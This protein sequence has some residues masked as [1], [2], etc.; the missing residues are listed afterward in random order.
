MKLNIVVPVRPLG[1]GK[2][3]LTGALSSAAR[4]DLVFAMYRHVV[5]TARRVGK[6]HVISRDAALLASAPNAIPELGTGLNAALR[7]AAHA[8]GGTGPIL[9]LNADLPLLSPFDIL[10]MVARLADADVVAAPD[11]LRIGT[12]ALLLARVGMI[13]YAFGENSLSAHRAQSRKCGLRFALCRRT[14]LASDVDEPSELRW[15][16]R[17]PWQH[18][19]DH[20]AQGRTP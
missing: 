16:C 20:M 14:G 15:A 13:E 5:Q 9:A 4:S 18:S 3:R 7:Q 12:N 17:L 19:V 6:V 2:T 8:I 1:E 10:A 11:H